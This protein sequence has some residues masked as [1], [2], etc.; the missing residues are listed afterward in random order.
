MLITVMYL[1]SYCFLVFFVKVVCF[2]SISVCSNCVDDIGREGRS[3]SVKKGEEPLF[4]PHF[5]GIL[6]SILERHALLI[7]T[8]M[9]D[10][11]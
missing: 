9:F 1:C 11:S 5:Q 6:F 7:P 10:E 3:S 4:L 8:N 2:W